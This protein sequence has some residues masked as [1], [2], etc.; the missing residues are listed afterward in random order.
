MKSPSAA[1]MQALTSVLNTNGSPF[2]NPT[3]Y[4]EYLPLAETLAQANIIAECFRNNVANCLLLIEFAIRLNVPVLTLAQNLQIINDKPAWSGKF[5]IAT[6]N[7]CGLFDRVQFEFSGEPGS[8]DYGCVAFATNL[9]TGKR[10]EGVKVTWKMVVDSGWTYEGSPW[11]SKPD[12][13]YHYRSASF[14]ANTNAAEVLLG[15]STVEEIADVVRSGKAAPAA[16]MGFK[17]ASSAPIDDGVKERLAKL[18][19]MLSGMPS[20]PPPPTIEICPVPTPSPAALMAEAAMKAARK[21]SSKGDTQTLSLLEG[22]DEQ[23]AGASSAPSPQAAAIVQAAAPQAAPTVSPPPVRPESKAVS[24]DN[25]AAGGSQTFAEQLRQANQTAAQ[26]KP[27]IANPQKSVPAPAAA[28]RP[29]PAPIP[30]PQ[31]SAPAPAK[32]PVAHIDLGTI[33]ELCLRANSSSEIADVATQLLMVAQKDR[34]QAEQEV[35]EASLIFL[36]EESTLAGMNALMEIIKSFSD[37]QIYNIYRGA[38]N[39][40]SETLRALSRNRNS[41]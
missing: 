36:G 11:L 25:G 20:P 41:Q 12:L 13:M 8:Y 29:A 19:L 38:Y 23:P 27:D 30:A 4:K 17:Q 21:R 2:A 33:K 35:L 26:S 40:R 34:V 32:V 7:T 9:A 31:A 6:L 5:V 18:D 22:M 3:T 10:V 37:K 39:A 16:P 14:F 28:Q 24:G 1:E 15:L